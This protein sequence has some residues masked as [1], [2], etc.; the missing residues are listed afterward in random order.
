MNDLE[1]ANFHQVLLTRQIRAEIMA[2]DDFISDRSVYDIIAYSIDLQNI[3]NLTEQ[4]NNYLAKNPYDLTFYFPIEFDMENDGVRPEDEEY[5]KK[6]DKRIFTLVPNPIFITGTIEQRK[7]KIEE[8][9][10]R[11]A[12]KEALKR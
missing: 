2:G 12:R 1:R 7:K 6:I 5:R 10:R 9:I 11:Y 3:D 4:A 8:E